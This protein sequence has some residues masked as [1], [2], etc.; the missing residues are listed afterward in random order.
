[1]KI[2]LIVLAWLTAALGIAAIIT[3]KTVG[4]HTQCH[5]LEA[6][7]AYWKAAEARGEQLPTSC[8]RDSGLW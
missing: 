3:T 8:K 4:H 2:T 7:T 1:M 5:T 6:K